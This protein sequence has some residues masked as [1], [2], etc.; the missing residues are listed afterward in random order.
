MHAGHILRLNL[1]CNIWVTNCIFIPLNIMFEGRIWPQNCGVFSSASVGPELVMGLSA[2]PSYLFSHWHGPV[3]TQLH[4]VC[5]PELQ[6][7]A[8]STG[9][10]LAPTNTGVKLEHVSVQAAALLGH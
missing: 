6:V 9:A 7:S 3:Q 10:R 1:S 8:L 2:S 4:V 5:E